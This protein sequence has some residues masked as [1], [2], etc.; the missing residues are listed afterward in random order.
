MSI[1][2]SCPSC[3]KTMRVPDAAARRTVRCKRCS[4]PIRVTAEQSQTGE[5]SPKRSVVFLKSR[6]ILIFLAIV[7]IIGLLIAIFLFV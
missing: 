5:G 6:N 1:L 4:N 3:K 7:A 2:I